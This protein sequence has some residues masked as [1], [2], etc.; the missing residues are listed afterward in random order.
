MIKLMPKHQPKLAF[1]WPLIDILSSNNPRPS[2]VAGTI[3][4]SSKIQFLPISMA[5]AVFSCDI[6][7]A[8]PTFAI[9]GSIP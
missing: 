9:G 3:G 5:I 6:P 7:K 1:I 2:Q 8:S 4:E